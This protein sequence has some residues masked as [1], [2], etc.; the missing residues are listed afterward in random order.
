MCCMIASESYLTPYIIQHEQEQC[1]FSI[2][3]SDAAFD[4]PNVPSPVAQLIRNPLQLVQPPEVHPY[5][6][7]KPTLPPANTQ[8]ML[9]T[10]GLKLNST[11]LHN[12][13]RLG[14]P[15]RFRAG[16]QNQKWPTCGQGG[17]ITPA[18]WGIPI[19]S[20]RGTKSEVAHLWAR[21]LH[22]PCR[23]GG[24]LRFRA[25]G[26]NQKWPTCGQGGYITPAA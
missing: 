19:A 12:P 8:T 24:P 6:L 1:F 7:H 11:W 20:E 21:W 14:D 13:C 23:L 15:L 25:G 5:T 16:G 26:E 22:N 2:K 9:P 3:C 18:A 4:H 10:N 17:Y